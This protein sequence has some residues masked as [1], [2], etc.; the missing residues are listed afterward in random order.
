MPYLYRNFLPSSDICLTSSGFSK[1]Y[2]C[3]FPN[4]TY[5]TL[6]SRSLTEHMLNNHGYIRTP[7]GKTFKQSTQK[8]MACSSIGSS[9]GPFS[10]GA[11]ERDHLCA[12]QRGKPDIGLT[13]FSDLGSQQQST[14]PVPAQLVPGYWHIPFYQNGI[15]MAFGDARPA[16]YCY[17]AVNGVPVPSHAA[18]TSQMPPA[19]LPSGAHDQ[20]WMPIQQQAAMPTAHTVDFQGTTSHPFSSSSSS[21]SSLSLSD[22][23]VDLLAEIQHPLMP[24]SV[25]DPSLILYSS[26]PSSNDGLSTARRN[27]NMSPTIMEMG[28]PD[29]SVETSIIPTS[30]N[31]DSIFAVH[32]L[33]SLY[34]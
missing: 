5:F 28:A 1:S 30:I 26:Y 7:R 23:G 27:M 13:F 24:L 20:L 10:Q 31:L 34:L 9:L 21:M 18:I 6:Y 25:E 14:C 12:P 22:S 19:E 32:N 11:D 2:A 8:P 33:S 4:C 17:G 16:H 29:Q 3:P 15:S